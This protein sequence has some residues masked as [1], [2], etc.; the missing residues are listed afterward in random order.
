MAIVFVFEYMKLDYFVDKAQITIMHSTKCN[1]KTGDDIRTKGTEEE[2]DR[3][4][5]GQRK[6]NLGRKRQREEETEEKRNIGRKG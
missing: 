6:R 5:K 4:R 3:G 1:K 2:T